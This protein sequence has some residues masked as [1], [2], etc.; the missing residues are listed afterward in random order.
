MCGLVWDGGASA[1]LC[2]LIV[3]VYYGSA[4]SR[5]LCKSIMDGL[6]CRAHV[7][8]CDFVC[9]CV[10]VHV[11]MVIIDTILRERERAVD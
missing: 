4:V 10:C 3:Q 7:Y 11:A 6:L 2:R 9:L 8:V 1:M 5:T